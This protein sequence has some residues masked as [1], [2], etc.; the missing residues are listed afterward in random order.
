MVPVSW[1]TTLSTQDVAPVKRVTWRR[2]TNT[3]P[4]HLTAL[5]LSKI[6]NGNP[7][8]STSHHLTVLNASTVLL[9]KLRANWNAS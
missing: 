3:S 1:D 2:S 7:S 6:T 8:S 4:S 9:W 5:A